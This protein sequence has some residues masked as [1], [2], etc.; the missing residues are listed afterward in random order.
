MHG[1]SDDAVTPQELEAELEV[2][3][4]LDIEG[5]NQQRIRLAGTCVA[6]ACGGCMHASRR[7]C[8]VLYADAATVATGNRTAGAP[9]ERLAYGNRTI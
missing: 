9:P 3:E 6:C 7:A 8:I 4:A 2:L 1:Q 5:A